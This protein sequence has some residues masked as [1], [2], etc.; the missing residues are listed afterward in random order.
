MDKRSLIFMAVLIASYFVIQYVFFPPQT[1]S[2]A[3]TTEANNKTEAVQ[4]QVFKKTE[5]RNDEE[6]YVLKNDSI[7]L[8]FSNYGGAIAEMNL[9]LKLS[10]N[11]Q[12]PINPIDIDRILKKSYPQDDQFPSKSYQDYQGYNNKTQLNEYYPLLRRSLKDF[13]ISP[14]YYACNLVG[15]KQEYANT[16]YTLDK[17]DK[18]QIIFSGK[19]GSTRITKT[20]TLSKT[21]PYFFDLDIKIDGEKIPL[22][23]TSGVPEVELSSGSPLYLLKAQTLNKKNKLVVSDS[24]LPKNITVEKLT[25]NWVCNGN[26][27]FGVI[28]DDKGSFSSTFKKEKIEGNKVPSRITIINSEHDLYPPNNF[29]GYQVLLPLQSEHYQ[30][31]SG[32]IQRTLL[33]QI[34]NALTDPVTKQNPQYTETV[35]VSGFFGFISIP[36]A[37]FLWIFLKFFHFI[38]HSWGFSIILL[39]IILRVLMYPLNTWTINAQSKMQDLS[40]KTKLLQERYKKDQNVYKQELLK[41]YREEKVNPLSGCLPVLIQLPFL[42]G[43]FDLLK[44]TFELRGASFIPGWI[45]NLAAPDTLFSWSYPLFIVGNQFH[46]LPIAL[47][48]VMYFQQKF[49]MKLPADPNNLSDQEKQQRMM[50]YLMPVL[51]VFIFYK[52]PSGLNIYFFVSTAL[53]IL[54]QWM[55]THKITFNWKKGK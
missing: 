1:P 52:M 55:I 53:G 8:V 31:F 20:Y 7:Q 37:K 25:T 43:F 12:S 17:L 54:Q 15:E 27:F 6:F 42:I 32:P 5:M 9:P 33:A 51:F 3:S 47:G 36:F 21:L 41:L 24:K 19:I 4:T 18:N 46:L 35:K 34:D 45:D 22:W 16:K 26:G 13:T 39:T 30:I 38:T 44:T 48:A 28:L 29:P 40:A 23:L 50:G 11:S 10:A 49:T 2:Q 14:A